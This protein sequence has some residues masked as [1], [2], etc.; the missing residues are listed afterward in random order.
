MSKKIV[1][2]V[3]LLTVLALAVPMPSVA[4]DNLGEDSQDA[5]KIARLKA[6]QRRAKAESSGVS[7]ASGSGSDACGGVNVGNVVNERGAKGPKEVT[8][9][10]T[11]DVIN[12]GNKCK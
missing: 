7:G 4:E 8:V 1:F 6:Q 3:S 11:G 2:V 10:I 9:V 12:M 5:A